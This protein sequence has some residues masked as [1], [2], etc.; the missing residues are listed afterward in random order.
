MYRILYC[1]LSSQYF[2]TFVRHETSIC[3]GFPLW[4]KSTLKGASRRT[5]DQLE[6]GKTE[7]MWVYIEK[8]KKN[9]NGDV[10]LYTTRHDTM[11]FFLHFWPNLS[12]CTTCWKLCD[13]DIRPVLEWTTLNDLGIKLLNL[14]KYCTSLTV[15]FHT[16]VAAVDSGVVVAL[17]HLEVYIHICDNIQIRKWADVEPC[18]FFCSLGQQFTS[19]LSGPWSWWHTSLL[20]FTCI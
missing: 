12:N 9:K 15:V 7:F 14:G 5:K 11:F 2:G 3:P 6:A 1:S 20:Q 13:N 4:C 10:P 16:D 8:I 19:S 17:H 18:S